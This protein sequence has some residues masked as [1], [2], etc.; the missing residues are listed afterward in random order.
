MAISLWFERRQWLDCGSRTLIEA[1]LIVKC[2]INSEA[3]VMCVE[4]ARLA[5]QI[6]KQLC[7]HMLT[8]AQPAGY[9]NCPSQQ[10]V[11]P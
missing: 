9:Q 6:T 4:H 7:P 10:C 1:Q 2:S 8:L 11:E 3:A 5:T